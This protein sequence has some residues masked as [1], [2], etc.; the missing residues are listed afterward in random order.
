MSKHDL[1]GKT[2]PSFSQ[3]ILGKLKIYMYQV[4]SWYGLFCGHFVAL[5]GLRKTV[6]TVLPH[7]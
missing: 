7:V 2:Q 6:I 4:Y 5:L 3:M 1:H